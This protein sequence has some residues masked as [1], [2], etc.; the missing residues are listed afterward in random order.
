MIFLQ[1]LAEVDRYF[2]EVKKELTFMKPK[3]QISDIALRWLGFCLTGMI[4]VGAL[5]WQKFERVSGGT[6]CQ[7]IVENVQTLS[8]H[9][10]GLPF[11]YQYKI[12]IESFQYQRGPPRY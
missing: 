8:K 2:S 9:P 5:C 4:I 3:C 7:G 1:N 12:F 11:Y 10:L 6:C